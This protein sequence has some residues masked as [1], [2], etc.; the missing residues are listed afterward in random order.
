MGIPL[1]LLVFAL[2]AVLAFAVRAEPSGLDL[3]AVGLILMLVSI[4]GLAVTL[5]RDQWRRRIVEESIEHGMPAPPDLDET[6][7]VDPAAPIEA[8]VHY[9]TQ[10][11]L[12]HEPEHGT[13]R[14]P[15]RE[16]MADRGQPVIN[17]NVESDDTRHRV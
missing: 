10:H 17:V 1:S 12:D 6:V 15:H 8:P 14:D 2:G 16:N 4:V 7:L 9:E 11:I 13:R 5:Y 3:T